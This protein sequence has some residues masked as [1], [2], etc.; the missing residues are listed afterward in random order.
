MKHEIT[1]MNCFTLEKQDVK[2]IKEFK[3]RNISEISP[4]VIITK[5]FTDDVE[6]LAVI[7]EV[8]GKISS[9]EYACPWSEIKN[10]KGFSD[11][12]DPSDFVKYLLDKKMLEWSDILRAYDKNKE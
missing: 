5:R 9:V 4:T 2:N 6:C 12:E 10:V 7:I 1:E 3:G 11:I 8:A